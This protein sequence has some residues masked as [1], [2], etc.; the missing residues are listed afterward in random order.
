MTSSGFSSLILESSFTQ[1][2][3]QG[4]DSHL[5]SGSVDD[6]AAV[7]LNPNCLK[8]VPHASVPSFLFF[9]SDG[10]KNAVGIFPLK[11]DVFFPADAARQLLCSSSNEDTFTLVLMSAHWNL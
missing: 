9:K 2:D 11:L 4:F 1:T 6:L 5:C 7:V 8:P 3:L 10:L